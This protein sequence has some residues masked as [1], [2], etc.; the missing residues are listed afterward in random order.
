MTEI[1]GHD[2]GE[3]FM[4][5]MY[6]GATFSVTTN[7]GSVHHEVVVHAL[8]MIL[9]IDASWQKPWRYVLTC[10]DIFGLFLHS[11]K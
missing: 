8:R 9:F 5:L 3:L 2:L 6:V 10:I 11:L 4:I 7:V 1:D